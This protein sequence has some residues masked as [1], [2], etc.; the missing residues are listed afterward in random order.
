MSESAFLNGEFL[1]LKDAKVSVEDRGFQFADGVYEVVR[2]YNGTPFY[3]VEHLAR[4]ER[5]ASEILLS[6]PYTIERFNEICSEL[7]RRSDYAEAALYLQVTRG[8]APRKH[9]FPPKDTP[10]TVVAYIRE[11]KGYPQEWRENG[12]DTISVPDLRWARCDIKSI[13]L[14]PNVL[15]K[16]KAVSSG[17]VE[18]IQVNEDG[19]V[20]EGSATNV[21]CIKDNALFT[22]PLGQ[23]IL[24]GITRGL[25][26]PLAERAGLEVREKLCRLPDLFEAD[27]L[28]ISSTTIEILPVRSIDGMEINEGNVPGEYTRKIYG[29]Y[30]EEVRRIC[31]D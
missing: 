20:T 13:A 6:L 15:A 4:L 2:V 10:R 30:R 11:F 12:I 8:A 28:F 17:A 18:A 24:P 9:Y 31:G 1:P 21:F 29:Y 16:Q 3:L 27:E 14:L 5:S 22:H 26:L 7:I 25:I 19:I 23:T